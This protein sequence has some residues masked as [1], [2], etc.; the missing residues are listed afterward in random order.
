M[1]AA[2]R[3]RRESSRSDR[4]GR[5]YG[6][7][8]LFLQHDAG[9]LYRQMFLQWVVRRFVFTISPDVVFYQECQAFGLTARRSP[10]ISYALPHFPF[11]EQS[12]DRNLLTIG[13]KLIAVLIA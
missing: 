12:M 1:V 2:M 13:S 7:D 9:K 10:T 8:S 6:G 5:L 11:E 3:C 4:F